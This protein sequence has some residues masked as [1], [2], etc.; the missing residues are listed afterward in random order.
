MPRAS[1]SRR[2]ARWLIFRTGIKWR[3]GGRK[4]GEGIRGVCIVAKHGA[5]EEDDEMCAIQKKKLAF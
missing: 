1:L 2:W 4:G 3:E 5:T